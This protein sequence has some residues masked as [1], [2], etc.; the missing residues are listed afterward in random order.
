MLIVQAIIA[1][2]TSVVKPRAIGYLGQATG[3]GTADLLRDVLV[4]GNDEMMWP[5]ILNEGQVFGDTEH[6]NKCHRCPACR[7]RPRQRTVRALDGPSGTGP[8]RRGGPTVVE[9]DLA[10][11]G[12][13]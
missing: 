8:R 13:L 7:C 12:L 2:L 1:P 4:Y 3:D 6:K 5:A 10:R 9:D 11:I